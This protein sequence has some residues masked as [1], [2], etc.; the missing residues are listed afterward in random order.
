[1][2]SPA[3]APNQS[4][5]ATPAIGDFF[6]AISGTVPLHR[7]KLIQQ[8]EQMRGSRVIC[9]LTSL[10]QGVPGQMA[11]DAIREILDQLLAISNPPIDKLDVFICSN[12][13][14]WSD[15]TQSLAC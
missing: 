14:Y 13:V 2:A 15:G 10:R 11:D 7:I 12:G 9:Y 4:A 1:M 6:H 3:P 5:H 8:I